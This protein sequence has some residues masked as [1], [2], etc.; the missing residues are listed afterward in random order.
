MSD[1]QNEDKTTERNNSRKKP[2]NF[3]SKKC[4]LLIQLA[5]NIDHISFKTKQ[6]P[7]M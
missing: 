3:P 2:M 5:R 1:E 4:L 7:D 6:Q